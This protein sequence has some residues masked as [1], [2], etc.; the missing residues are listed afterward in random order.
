M[1]MCTEM[2]EFV[3]SNLCYDMNAYMCK[4]SW[5]EACVMNVRVQGEDLC[6][7]GQRHEERQDTGQLN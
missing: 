4:G 5:Q 7:T 2:P 6:V 3:L 1:S